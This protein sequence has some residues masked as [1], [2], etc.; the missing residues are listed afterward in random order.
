M[1]V[2]N[3]NKAVRFDGN[4]NNYYLFNNTHTTLIVG[5]IRR[6]NTVFVTVQLSTMFW[7]LVMVLWQIWWNEL[8]AVCSFI[9]SFV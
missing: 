6:V 5:S 1:E 8:I 7:E 4:F 9:C 3:F 2:M